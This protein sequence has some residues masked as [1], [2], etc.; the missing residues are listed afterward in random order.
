[1]T[2]EQMEMWD[3]LAFL[4]SERVVGLFTDFYGL[5]LLDHD[6]YEYLQDEGVIDE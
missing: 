1:M 2:D 6:F 5:Q 4:S 3:A